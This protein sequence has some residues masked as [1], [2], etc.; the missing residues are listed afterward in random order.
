MKILQIINS[1][2]T[3]GAEKLLLET[4]PLYNKREIKVDL[5]V[6]DGKEYPFLKELKRKQCCTIY[7]LGKSSVYNPLLIF[8]IIPYLKKYDVVHVHLFP[9]LYWVALAKL[10]S[11]SKIKLIYT[12][13]STNNK[14]R[15]SIL[16]KFIDKIIYK[17]YD[18]LITIAEEVDLNLKKHVDFK[19]SKFQLIKNG[20]NIQSFFKAL[21]YSKNDFFSKNDLILI[22]VSSFR[23]PKDQL[24]LIKS[25]LLL[26]TNIKLVLVGDGEDRNNCENLVAKLN[27]KERVLFLGVRVDVPRLLKTADIVV[28]STKYEG[29][30]LSSIEGMASGKPFIA[31]EVPGLTKVVKGAGLLFP[32]GDSKLLSTYISKLA[33]NESYYTKVANACIERAKQ[34]DINKM[35]DKHIEVYKSLINKI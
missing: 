20:V 16:F 21:P 9:S 18:K 28:L 35:V 4:I 6:L 34:Y 13:H 2:N 12:E 10:I 22:Q 15:N 30:S 29:L 24:T 5:L 14:R 25:L 19:T 3:G 31:S 17:P 11:F 32:Q 23:Y 7:S 8:K 33:N 26:P 1:L 27:L